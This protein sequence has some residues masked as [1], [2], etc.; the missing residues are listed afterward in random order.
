MHGKMKFT[1]CQPESALHVPSSA[2][3]R[4]G[5]IPFLFK[6]ENGVV[7]R[8]SIVIQ[9]DNGTTAAVRW[10]V[11]RTTQDL[12]PAEGIVISNQG[13]LQDGTIIQATLAN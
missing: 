3:I 1:V 6:N 7:R 4:E 9:I 8:K 2:I 10:S 13:E 12:S 11:N 5:V